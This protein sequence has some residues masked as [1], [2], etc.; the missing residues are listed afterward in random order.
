MAN[1]NSILQKG[2]NSTAGSFLASEVPGTRKK[3]DYEII[4]IGGFKAFAEVKNTRKLTQTAPNVTLEDGTVISETVFQGPIRITITGKVGDVYLEYPQ[5]ESFDEVEVQVVSLTEAYL[6]DYAAAQLT[7]IRQI[8]DDA[9]EALDA[10]D[11]KIRDGQRL[12]D[13]F[14]DKSGT[15]TFQ[16][17]FIDAIDI[18]WTS[19]ALT[20]LETPFRVYDNVIIEDFTTELVPESDEISFNITAKVVRLATLDTVTIA[21]N[22][23][24]GLQGRTNKTV[25]KGATKGKEVS[26]SLLSTV[27][28]KF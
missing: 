17:Q 27:L 1:V 9:L 18:L 22:P 20:T 3:G 28:G 25:N 10:L 24:S 13:L 19:G 2:T 16:E 14:G 5:N 6:P 4:G 12:L 26:Q 11:A 15:K 8:R 21:K 23:S 7:R